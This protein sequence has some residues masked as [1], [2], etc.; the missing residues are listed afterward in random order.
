MSELQ[1][2]SIP[3][4]QSF[5]EEANKLIEDKSKQEIADAYQQALA[6]A[7]GVGLTLEELIAQGKETNPKKLRKKVEP[8]Y[9][10]TDN[11]LEV[12]T[13]R[14]KQPRWLTSRIEGGAKL[15]DFAI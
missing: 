2:K 9:R 5:I 11:P 1:N 7:E 3:E 15:E 8:R 10:N 12:W 4:L 6:L 13:G 14:G